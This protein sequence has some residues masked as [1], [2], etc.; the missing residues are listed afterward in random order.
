MVEHGTWYAPANLQ[1]PPKEADSHLCF[2]GDEVK[3]LPQLLKEILR[4]QNPNTLTLSHPKNDVKILPR[5]LYERK[6]TYIY[7]FLSFF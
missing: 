7:I 1:M 6:L 3:R 4:S 2:G 5:S